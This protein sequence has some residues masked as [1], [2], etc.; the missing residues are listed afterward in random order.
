[1]IEVGSRAI[2]FV[3]T[4]QHGPHMPL[5]T[6]ALIGDHLARLVA[7]RLDAFVAPTVR[8]G[9]PEHHLSRRVP[10]RRGSSTAGGPRNSPGRV[11]TIASSPGRPGNIRRVV[12]ICGQTSG[13]GV[14]SLLVLALRPE[15]STQARKPPTARSALRGARRG[16]WF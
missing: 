7:E 9:C 13:N 5:A 16:N 15:F 3:A 6:D 12:V 2:A 11:Q 10:S 1:V 14:L 8:M 4:E